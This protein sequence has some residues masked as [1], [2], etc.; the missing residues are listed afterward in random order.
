M[1][2]LFIFLLAI[3]GGAIACNNS[4]EPVASSATTTVDSAAKAAADTL[5]PSAD[6]T[7]KKDVPIKN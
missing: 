7:S 6:T 3:T 1:Q 5:R 2:K 4:G